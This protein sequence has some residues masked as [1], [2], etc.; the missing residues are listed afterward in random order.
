MKK[1]KNGTNGTKRFHL[2]A[3][4]LAI[5]SVVLGSFSLLNAS[6]VLMDDYWLKNKNEK[7]LS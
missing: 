1:N 5:L 2:A 7:I 4:F 3:L 6:I